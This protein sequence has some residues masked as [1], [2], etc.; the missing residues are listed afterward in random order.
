MIEIL[1][2]QDENYMLEALIIALDSPD[3]ST[4]NGAVLTR[5]G[6]VS[7]GCNR[8]PNKVQYLPERW[9][10]P[11]KY[12]YIEHA[13]R[14]SIFDAARSGTS[15]LGTTMFCPW[16][17]CADCARAIIQ[18]GIVRV[19]GLTA[20]TSHE[21]WNEQIQ[22]GDTMMSEAGVEVVRGRLS[23]IYQIKLLRNG[24]TITF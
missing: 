7:T 15:T 19:V 23:K 9:E 17:A 21:R 12:S 11:A 8:F 24:E 1:E 20:K 2:P 3:P 10:R 5:D 16:F 4:Q 13:E 18:A 14:N 22:V 6:I